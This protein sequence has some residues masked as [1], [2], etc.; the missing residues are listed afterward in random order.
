MTEHPSAARGGLSELE[1]QQAAEIIRLEAVAQ[2]YKDH[3]KRLSGLLDQITND[4]QKRIHRNLCE[5]HRRQ[6]EKV[7]K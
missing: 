4:A 1:I 3:A 2:V 6:L 7:N 5:L